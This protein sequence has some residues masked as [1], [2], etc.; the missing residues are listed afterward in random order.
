M[1]LQS[2]DKD[3][4][5]GKTDGPSFQIYGRNLGGFELDDSD[6]DDSGGKEGGKGKV[7][8]RSNLYDLEE[9]VGFVQGVLEEFMVDQFGHGHNNNENDSSSKVPGSRDDDDDDST[10]QVK[11]KVIL[12]G[13]S[14][15]SYIAMEVLRRHREK[16]KLKE[17]SK[18]ESGSVSFDIIGGIMLFPTVVDIAKSASGRKLTV[19]TY[20]H[21]LFF[22]LPSS[23]ILYSSKLISFNRN[24]STSFPNL[25]SLP[26]F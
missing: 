14:V 10:V 12:I 5:L 3:G 9:Q 6:Y 15:G 13:H 22:P 19:C 2:N 11:P 7:T 8:T 4:H 25:L 18:T 26:A 23:W 1:G 17:Q 20:I 16:E 24:S 21:S